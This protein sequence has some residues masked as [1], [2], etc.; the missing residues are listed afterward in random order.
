MFMAAHWDHRHRIALVIQTFI[1][2]VLSTS[3]YAQATATPANSISRRLGLVFITVVL[4]WLKLGVL[5]LVVPFVIVALVVLAI[6]NPHVRNSRLVKVGFSLVLLG[7]FVLF[8]AGILGADNA[9]GIGMLFAFLIPT[10]LF[11]TLIGTVLALSRN[12]ANS[13]R[14]GRANLPM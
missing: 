4:M 7:F 3:I 11:T 1:V 12:R 13:E 9:I 6:K 2:S 10:G 5:R 14:P 8:L